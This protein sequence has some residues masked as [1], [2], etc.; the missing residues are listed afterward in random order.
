MS[1]RAAFIYDQEMSRHVLRPDH[2]MRPVRL[3]QTCELLEAYGAFEGDSSQFLPP[4]PATE[5]EIERFHHAEY[6]QAV[7][8]FSVGE[9]L[10]RASRFNFSGEGDNPIYQG[11]Y[12]AA[13][14]STGGSLV[15]AELVESGD[16]DVAFNISGGLHHAAAGNPSGFCVFNDPVVAVRYLLTKGLRV[17]Y[18]DIDAHH[19]DGVQTAFY[20]TDQ[21]LT[22]SLHESGMFLFPGTGGVEE[23]G[24]GPGKG[25]SINLPLYPGTDDQM[26]LRAFREVVPLL[27]KAFKPDILATQ[28]GIDTYHTDPLT[29]LM[30]SSSGF[31]QAVSDLAGMG[32]PWLAFGGGGYDLGAV[33]RCWTLAYGVMV[34]RE[35]PDDLPGSYVGKYGGRHLRDAPGSVATIP[36]HIR[37][38]AESFAEN[39]V[40]MLKDQ[41]FPIHGIK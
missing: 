33:A 1:R 29:H 17:V 12:E 41:V 24:V 37:L 26:Y 15:A 36:E 20:D 38:Q 16:A 23:M 25:Y 39:S 35:F 10:D 40:R 14:L 9:G 8:E 18:V 22:I 34:E 28:L 31:E 19:G 4:R 3:Q 13:A 11:M 32:I 6:I 5:E 27:V 21:V 7:K 2:P 30:L